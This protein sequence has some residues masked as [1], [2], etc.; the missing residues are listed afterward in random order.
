[1]KLQDLIS[2][3]REYAEEA[4]TQED[5][6]ADKK[7]N[8]AAMFDLAIGIAIITDAGNHILST[9]F[10]KSAEDYSDIVRLLGEVGVVPQQIINENKDM[11]KFRNLLIHEYADVDFKK[12]YAYLQKAPDVFQQFADSYSTFLDKHA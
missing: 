1:M 6:I 9:V 2:D 4:Q 12:V 8:G 5:F 7:L 11:T 10:Q 3:L